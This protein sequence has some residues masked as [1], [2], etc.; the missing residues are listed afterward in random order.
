MIYARDLAYIHHAGFGDFARRAAPG[1]LRLLRQRGIGRGL[2][3]D[4]GC[5]SGI[6]AA[7]LTR[8][9]YAVHGI[10]RSSAMI[11]LA[12]EVAPAATFKR[13][14][15]DSVPVPRCDAVTALGEVFGYAGSAP[16]PRLPSLFRRVAKALRPGGLFVLD[17]LVRGGRAPMRYR[18]WTASEEWAVLV[19]V[20]EDIRRGRVQ[21]DITTFRQDGGCFRRHRERHLLY[22]MD[23]DSLRTQLR[24]AGFSVRTSRHYGPC[25]LA[26]RRLAFICD[27]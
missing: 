4:I 11:R 10:D 8:A 9:G 26:R 7:E 25:A 22:V 13:G 3:V 12:R 27:L 19:D 2:I 21:R 17:V 15:F 23:A 1:V 24:T 16:R 20:D 5:G 14:S 6:L 18:T